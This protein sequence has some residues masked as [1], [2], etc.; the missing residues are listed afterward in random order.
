MEPTAGCAGAQSFE[1]RVRYFRA[2]IRVGLRSRF[3]A[4][5]VPP[6]AQTLA[7]AGN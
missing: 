7:S 3:A 1:S 5:C 4:F 2:L 6:R